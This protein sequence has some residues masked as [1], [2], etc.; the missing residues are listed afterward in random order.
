MGRLWNC[1]NAPQKSMAGKGML[2][3]WCFGLALLA[4][5]HTTGVQA[6]PD[7]SIH[8]PD[9]TIGGAVV[10]DSV[11]ITVSAPSSAL[12]ERATIKL[13][14]RDVTSEFHPDGTA[15]SLSGV[16]S[17]LVPGANTFEMFSRSGPKGAVARLVVARASGPVRTCESLASLSGFPIQPVGAI[18]GTTITSAVV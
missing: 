9:V 5:L 8:S 11:R 16:V 13:N 4:M 1:G 7:Y 2:A 18:G 6:N 10:G 3:S 15:G 14:G 12:I 17:G